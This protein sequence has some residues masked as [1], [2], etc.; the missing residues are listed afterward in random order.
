MSDCPFQLVAGHWTCPQ[1][2]WV[3]PRAADRPP[4][5]NCPAGGD[6]AAAFLVRVRA[7]IAARHSPLVHQ[8]PHVI[9]E[10]LEQCQRCEEWAG[11]CRWYRGC[12]AFDRF[13][14]DLLLGRCQEWQGED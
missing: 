7:S 8:P 3:Y 12:E 1:C 14:T 13:V 6:A 11:R 4:R 5:R 2:G 10:H 9:A